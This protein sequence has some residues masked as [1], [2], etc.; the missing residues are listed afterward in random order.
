MKETEPGTI[1]VILWFAAFVVIALILLASITIVPAGNAGVYDLFGSVRDEELT[2][3]LHFVNP[4]ARIH[5]LSVQTQELKETAIVPSKEGLS[6]SLDVSILYKL[7]PEKASEVYKTIGYDYL[8]V[9][10]VPQMR[11][12]IRGVTVNHEAKALY[13]AEREI[14]TDAIMTDL[15]PVLKERGIILEKALLREIR[16]PETVA[17]AI[18]VKL[19]AEQDAQKMKFVLEKEKLEADRK[20]TEAQGISDANKIIAGSLTTNYLTWYWISNLDKSES[21]M[22]VP[23]GQNGLPLFKN[24][25]NTQ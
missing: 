6:V 9:V 15:A 2:P 7:M 5:K 1:P 8:E 12:A 25:D 3:G 22:Y 11:A 17:K 18:E 20:R 21:V 10:V 16:L 14:I 19:S 13:T 24:V 23:V 4:L